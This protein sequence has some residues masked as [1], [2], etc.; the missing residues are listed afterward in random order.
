MKK[1]CKFVAL[2][3][4]VMLAVP[5]TA[6]AGFNLGG[7]RINLPGSSSSTTGSSKPAS[8]KAPGELPT[9]TAQCD[10]P[11]AICYIA[12]ALQIK[13][14]GRTFVVI[15]KDNMTS[16]GTGE[17]GKLECFMPAKYHQGV[18]WKSGADHYFTFTRLNPNVGPVELVR[19]EGK[20]NNIECKEFDY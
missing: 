1:C 3:M 16:G 7:V 8:N 12:P 11:Y 19:H 4:L 5:L 10:L 6:S 20:T 18:I 9:T 2:A 17:T 15:G 14:Q 13:I